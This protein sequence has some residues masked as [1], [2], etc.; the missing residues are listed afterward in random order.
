MIAK[1]STA[2]FC[3]AV[4]MLVTGCAS[5]AP[6]MV[7][8]PDLQLIAQQVPAIASSTSVAVKVQDRRG[9][10][11]VITVSDDSDKKQ[12]ISATTPPVETIKQQFTELLSSLRVNTSASA[13][14]KLTLYVDMLDVRIKQSHVAHDA[15]MQVQFTLVIETSS[16]TFKKPFYGNMRL[17]G[18]FKYDMAVIEK[19][20]NLLVESVF[21]KMLKDQEVTT[22]F[23]ER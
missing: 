22:I 13:T 21:Q 14:K 6:S 2:A 15:S 10:S 23:A 11:H 12:L 5:K 16:N 17:E 18:L 1:Q 9:I 4:L 8:H 3:I 19:E 7:F 20:L